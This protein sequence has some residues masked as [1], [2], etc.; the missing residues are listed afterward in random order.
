MLSL[1]LVV[2]FFFIKS[3]SPFFISVLLNVH[4]YLQL[5]TFWGQMRVMSPPN[6]ENSFL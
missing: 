2:E 3:S 6:R 4:P 1:N 5:L